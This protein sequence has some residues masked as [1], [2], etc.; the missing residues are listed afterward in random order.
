MLNVKISKIY[1][2]VQSIKLS[3][4]CNYY[5]NQLLNIWGHI[6]K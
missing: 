3:K 2:N 6:L 1:E 5:S 4:S